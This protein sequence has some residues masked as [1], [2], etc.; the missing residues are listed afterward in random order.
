VLKELRV[1]E[2]MGNT[3]AS[4]AIKQTIQELIRKGKSGIY[5]DAFSCLGTLKYHPHLKERAHTLRYDYNLPEV[6]L[7]EQL[8]KNSLGVDFHRQKMAG[9]FI[10]DLFCPELMLAIEIDGRIHELEEVEIR[11]KR[12]QEWLESC[13]ID[14]LRFSAFAIF[15]QL[16]SVRKELKAYVDENIIPG[17]KLTQMERG[18]YNRNRGLFK[19]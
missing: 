11:D 15:K 6:L 14:F 8:K 4:Q 12:R 3:P 16:D 5:S 13:G 1:M 18:V 10:L 7:W 17:I 9:S 19:G 2:I